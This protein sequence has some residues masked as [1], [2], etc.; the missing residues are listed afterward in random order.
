VVICGCVKR[1][2]ERLYVDFFSRSYAFFPGE[3]GGIPVA[4][5]LFGGANR[6]GKLPITLYPND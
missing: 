5:Q 3:M 1:G 4:Q 6:W 2:L